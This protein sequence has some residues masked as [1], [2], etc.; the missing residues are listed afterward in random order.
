MEN[1]KNK[2]GEQ[3][4]QGLFLDRNNHKFIYKLQNGVEFEVCDELGVQQ[5]YRNLNTKHLTAEIYHQTLSS[6]TTFECDLSDLRKTAFSKFLSNKGVIHDEGNISLIGCYL[7][8]RISDLVNKGKINFVHEKLGWINEKDMIAGY[9]ASKSINAFHTSYMLKNDEKLIGQNGDRTVYEQMIQQEVIPNKTLHLP[10]VLGFVAPLVPIMY[11]KTACPVLITN[12]AG[13]SSQGKS[14]S[15]ALI[16]S[17]WG[18]GKVSNSRLAITKTFASTQNGFEASIKSNYGFPALFDD[19]ETSSKSINFAQLI[20]TLA[21]GESKTR[22]SK[23]GN[24]NDTFS[25]RTYVGLTGESSIFDRAGNNLGLRPRIVEFKNTAWTVS[26][27]NSINITSVV[28]KHYGFYG[29]EFVDRLSKISSSDLD[30]LYSESESVINS[31]I[32][33]KDNISDRIQTRLSLIRMAAVLVVKLMQ[34]NVDVDYITDTLVKNEISRQNEPDIF[35][36][37]TE[38]IAEFVNTNY[39]SF[40]IN[41]DFTGT[42]TI[43]NKQIFGRIYTGRQGLLIA[44]LPEFLKKIMLEFNDKEAI[45]EKWR[46]EKLLVTDDDK[47]YTKLARVNEDMIATRCYCFSYKK[48]SELYGY[49]I[50]EEVI[51]FSDLEIDDIKSRVNKNSVKTIDGERYVKIPTSDT[52]VLNLRRTKSHYLEAIDLN[53]G[54]KK[55]EELSETPLLEI[56]YEEDD[57]DI[58]EIFRDFNEGDKDDENNN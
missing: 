8:S 17:I 10:L 45:F 21:Q 22:L 39:S 31:L 11:D 2:K 24:I 12:F 42:R 54:N 37:A 30:E 32:P 46:D 35:Q 1:K 28:T 36:K 25:W 52:E 3:Q 34:L 7:K 55:D 5:V 18:S 58:E 6:K 27:E 33:P 20:Y 19:Y 26:K 41:D 49:V 38:K 15:L 16:A 23:A 44:I 51:E 53:S 48:L 4:E 47:R 29:E 9:N 13:K 40:I 43:P 56:K 57:E 50:G 14:T